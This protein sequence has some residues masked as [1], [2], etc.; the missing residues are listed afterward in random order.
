MI[1]CDI[2]TPL[3]LEG[4]RFDEEE[5]EDILAKL[6][7]TLRVKVT[8]VFDAML[9][10]YRN[11]KKALGRKKILAN[12]KGCVLAGRGQRDERERETNFSG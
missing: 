1:Q 10:S 12:A 6:G 8:S 5:A 4:Q 11:V 3:L 2:E 7:P 9:L